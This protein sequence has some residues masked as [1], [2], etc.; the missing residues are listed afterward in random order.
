L[1]QYATS[2]TKKVEKSSEIN[3]IGQVVCREE[4]GTY[5]YQILA[6]NSLESADKIKQEV[7][8]IG[9]KDAFTVAYKNGERITVQEALKESSK[10]AQLER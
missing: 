4:N 10:I 3:K 2:P 7:K 8:K 9:Y 5:K 6:G 1:I